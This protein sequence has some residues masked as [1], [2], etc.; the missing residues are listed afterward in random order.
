MSARPRS[1][2]TLGPLLFHWSGQKRRDF[3][4]RIADEAP[5]DTVY[6]GEVVC[7]KRESVFALFRAEVIERLRTFY[8]Q[9]YQ[10]DN[11][12]VIVAG[13]FARDVALR[14]IASLF[15]R[16]PRPTRRLHPTYTVEPVQDG[17]HT[18]TVRRVGDVQVVA[19]A[20]HAVAA[21]DA[22]FAAEE[23]AADILAHEGSGRLYKALVE[24]GLAS[25]VCCVADSDDTPRE[26]GKVS[27]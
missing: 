18:A 10:P 12:T 27:A 14:H 20:Y 17:E 8:R 6:L 23:A 4:F 24:P 26:R 16:L 25:S 5:V 7:S 15:G 13:G 11:A 9:H 1:R 21:A 3:Y 2:L 22:D 19:L